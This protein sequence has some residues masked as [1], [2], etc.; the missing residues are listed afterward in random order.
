MLLRTLCVAGDGALLLAPVAFSGPRLAGQVGARLFLG[1]GAEPAHLPRN[2]ASGHVTVTPHSARARSPRR[3]APAG[4]RLGVGGAFRH[5]GL[6]VRG[7]G[8][9][10]PGAEPRQRR[11]GHGQG[12]AGCSRALGVVVAAGAFSS[13]PAQS[14]PIGAARAFAG[15]VRDHQ[16]AA[17]HQ[18]GAEPEAQPRQHPGACGRPVAP[19]GPETRVEDAER[20]RSLPRIRRCFKSTSRRCRPPRSNGR[21]Q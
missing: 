17:A 14:R 4:R 11:R 13:R 8:A 6:P 19:V 5:G 9:Q 16:E 10:H 15:R 12:A 7:R 18:V 3:C 1:P 2:G 21:R 20:Q